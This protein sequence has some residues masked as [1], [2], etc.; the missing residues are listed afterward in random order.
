MAITSVGYD[1]TVNEI[2]W[3]K[4]VP[5]VGTASYGVATAAD[6]KVTAH[7]STPFAVNV[8][9]GTGWGNGVYDTSDTVVTVQCDTVPSGTTRYDLIV[10]R[11]SWAGTGGST[12]FTKIN[13]GA[14][15]VLPVRNTVP[16]VLDDQP[17]ALIQWTG[18]SNQPTAI[19]DLRVYAANGGCVAKD[20]LALTYLGEL[21]STVTINGSTWICVPTGASDTPTWTNTVQAG[22]IGLFGR[23]G[24]LVG[25]TPAGN[26]FL[27]Q[28]GAT[29][30][31]TNSSGIGT[32]TFPTPF[33][34]GLV[35][36]LLTDGDDS[37]TGSDA[38][39]SLRTAPTITSFKFQA[40]YG[41]VGE[42]HVGSMRIN[43][44]AIGW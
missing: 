21:G 44:I 3:A 33:P 18:G 4:M 9:A 13:G 19:Y 35:T 41:P 26:T 37:A 24:S 29:V 16:G 28:A 10:A 14:S 27:I 17:L 43:W 32:V 22:A 40:I 2:Q 7:P 12:T 25:G 23:S 20:E 38:I 6:L 15:K 8:A 30:V 34:T 1:G 5:K 39:V 42:P 36:V 31:T 11:R